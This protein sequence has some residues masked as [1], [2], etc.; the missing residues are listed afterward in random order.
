[1]KNILGDL[2]GI[3][4]S[5]GD[6]KLNLENGIELNSNFYSILNFKKNSII[7]TSVF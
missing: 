6:I 3:K 1:M 5:E 4:I 2:G 7:K